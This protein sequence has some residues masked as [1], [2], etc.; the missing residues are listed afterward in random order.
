[1]VPNGSFEIYDT[2]PYNAA[3]LSFATPWFSPT[4]GTPE[5]YNACSPN[6]NI[7]NSVGS[8]DGLGCAGFNAVTPWETEYLAVKLKEPLVANTDYCV[9][10]YTSVAK[11]DGKF[12][13][14]E[15]IGIYL[16]QDSIYQSGYWYLHVSPQIR[17]TSPIVDTNWVWVYGN[18]KAQGGE[19][20]IYI[21]NFDSTNNMQHCNFN[22]LPIKASILLI[23]NVSVFESSE[24]DGLSGI[25]LPNV[26]TSNGDG[27][28]DVINIP[29]NMEVQTSVY[30]RWGNLISE[31]S[32]NNIYWDGTNHGSRCADGVYFMIVRYEMNGKQKEKQTF[33][34][35]FH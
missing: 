24:C 7:P 12:C 34:Q 8:E 9:S 5:L 32:G 33:I 23:D 6:M 25:Q 21:G 15:K 29:V 19:Q 10:F 28:N 18:Y 17:N 11:G 30:N 13:S 31:H 2:C 3:Q 26:L 1:M 14:I 20:Y 16:S 35:L 27:V 4:Q 22:D